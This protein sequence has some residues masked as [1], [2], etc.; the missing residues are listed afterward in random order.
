MGRKPAANDDRDVNDRDKD[1]GQLWWVDDEG[2]WHFVDPQSSEPHVRCPIDG[3]REQEGFAFR[4]L[5][6]AKVKTTASRLSVQYDV[7]NVAPRAADSV[8]N[9]LDG[10]GEP[11]P[12]DL[13]FFYEG[14]NAETQA[15]QTAAVDR[16]DQ[17]L[18][19]R[20][21]TLLSTVMLHRHDLVDIDLC[22][23]PIKRVYRAWEEAQGR[24]TLEAD[25]PFDPL[26]PELHVLLPLQHSEELVFAYVGQRSAI[27]DVFGVDWATKAAG[28]M[29]LPDADYDHKVN[30]SYGGVFESGVPRLDH[31]RALIKLNNADPV[32]KSYQR[33]VAPT[34]LEDG[35][36]A[37]VCMAK[38]T[39][40]ISIKFMAGAA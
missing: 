29:H 2:A 35:S 24:L 33:L 12:V 14:W 39:D 7:N 34:V 1:P 11:K 36:P 18:A 25:A 6:F 21:V 28:Q 23:N 16:I 13:K 22:C 27:A 20:C 17:T 40:D 10:K 15:S 19:Y 37:L 26:M 9:Y 32:W 30:N 5:G 8:M 4:H 3:S 31:I 38:V